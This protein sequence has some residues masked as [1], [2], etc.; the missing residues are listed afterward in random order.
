MG[1]HGIEPWTMLIQAWKEARNQFII[2][3]GDRVY[4]ELSS[5]LESFL[6][7]LSDF[8]VIHPLHLEA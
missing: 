4:V 3:Y 8:M 2:L 7:A 1:L 5:Q 6:D